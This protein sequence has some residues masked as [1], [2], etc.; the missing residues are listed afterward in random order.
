MIV[1]FFR[2]GGIPPSANEKVVT[3]DDGRLAIWRST[4][5]PAAGSFVGQLSPAES[6]EIQE[7]ALRCVEAG[8]LTLEPV[9]DAA[10]D[11]V[12]LDGAKA[13]VGHLDRP[14]GPWGD[15]LDLLRPLLDR[16]DR[17]LAAIG[18][19]VAPAGDR[20]WLKHLGEAVVRADLS[21]LHVEAWLRAPTGEAAGAW[22]AVPGEVAGAEAGPVEVGPGWTYEL[23]FDHGFAPGS[24]TV[25]AIVTLVIYERE[26]PVEAVLVASSNPPLP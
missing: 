19:E 1:R 20:A 3:V 16:V 24:G 2:T 17:P 10:I 6:D 4:G 7:L 5:V 13:E 12:V 21:S 11:T 25:T 22:E 23:P 9:P 26:H 14:D 15:L 18:L 8:N